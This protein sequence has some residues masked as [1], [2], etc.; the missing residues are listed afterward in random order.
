MRVSLETIGDL[1][2]KMTV[3]LPSGSIDQEVGKR[4]RSMSK[5][6]KID[7][8][9]PGKV[10]FKLIQQRFGTSVYQDVVG[11]LVQSSLQD[12][13]QREQVTPA[14]TPEIELI[15]D[16]AEGAIEY[17]AVFEVYPEI[18]LAPLEVLQIIRFIA[19]VADT[20]VDQMIET[21]RKQNRSWEPANRSATDGDQIILDYR[22]LRN[23]K[24]FPGGTAE[25]QAIILGEGHLI[26]SLE[27]QLHGSLAGDE[28]TL[29]VTF[30][31]DYPAKDLAGQ[32]AQ[33]EIQ[34][35]KVNA[36]VLP[37]V[38]EAFAALFGIES[39]EVEAL[40]EEVRRNMVRELKAA[41]KE[42]TK[43]HVMDALCAANEITAP[44]SLVKAEIRRMREQVGEAMSTEARKN[45]PDDLFQEQAARRINLGLLI[46]ELVH[47]E[48]IS[49]D[50]GRVDETLRILAEGYEEPEQVIQYYRSNNETIKGIEALVL[51]DQVVDRIL[52]KA[53]VEDENQTFNQIM[54]PTQG[55]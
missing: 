23:D 27:S 42:Q 39:G 20:D 40:R 10:P 35:K 51:E 44:K 33:F 28:R 53:Q 8:F 21:L 36:P 17:T 12:A 14:G 41:L 54:N 49:L 30:P 22:G 19:E 48:K 7:G 1:E 6:I 32:T 26:G 25:N 24:P 38:D 4:L 47:N 31:E 29:D 9:R 46:A 15:P 55:G 34:V 50:S 2:R 37:T 13:I 45:L 3:R 43:T 52:E 5:R 18:E 11:D 16:Q